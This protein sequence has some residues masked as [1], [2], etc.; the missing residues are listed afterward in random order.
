[1]LRSALD[2]APDPM[3]GVLVYPH[4]G[5]GSGALEPR[6]PRPV[7][8]TGAAELPVPDDAPFASCV[9]SHTYEPV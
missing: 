8:G 1:V 9:S 2:A 3:S 7:L 6:R 5:G 4:R